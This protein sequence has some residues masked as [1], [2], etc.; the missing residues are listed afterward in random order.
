M[1]LGIDAGVT[2]P[3]FYLLD[4]EGRV[5]IQKLLTST[6]EPWDGIRKGIA[7]R[8]VGI[9]AT[10]VHGAT[11]ASNT[12]LERRA[13]GPRHHRAPSR[14]AGDRAPRP[15]GP[16]RPASHPARAPGAPS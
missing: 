9:E 6:R 2:F 16:L 1:I 10:V 12:L 4:G 15:D 3:G 5:R 8:D 11:V 7:D 13:H 14:R